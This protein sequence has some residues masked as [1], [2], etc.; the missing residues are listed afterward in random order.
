MTRKLG[1]FSVLLIV[2]G[3]LSIGCSDDSSKVTGPGEG[4][5][6]TDLLS[7]N[8]DWPAGSAQDLD[9]YVAQ[10]YFD[11]DEETVMDDDEGLDSYDYPY[12]PF[13]NDDPS[14]KPIDNPLG[15]D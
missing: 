8:V 15:L 3:C 6:P 10:G 14:N 5:V 11:P 2:L 7:T 1:S 12:E 13:I 9:E 4:I